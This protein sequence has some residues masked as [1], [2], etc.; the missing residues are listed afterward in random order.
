[1][2]L[3]VVGLGVGVDRFFILPG[4]S[5]CAFAML[6]MSTQQPDR[7]GRRPTDRDKVEG[8]VTRRQ[9]AKHIV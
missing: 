4:L 8:L 5:A 7:A 2:G 1:M 3:I 9:T 6:V